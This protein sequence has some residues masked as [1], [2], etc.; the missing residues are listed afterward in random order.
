M[1]DHFGWEYKGKHKDLVA[2]YQQLLLYREALENPPLLVVCDLD[3]FE[4][5]TNFTGTAKQVHAFDLDGL[6]EAANLA[7]LRRPLHGAGLARPASPEKVTEDAAER[8][9]ELADGMRHADV[10]PRAAHFLMKL[11]FCMFGEDI[12][13]LPPGLRLAAET[14]KANP[15]MLPRL[16]R[17]CSTPW[18]TGG[19]F[20]A[21]AIDWFNG[22]LFADADVIPLT[23][24]E[25]NTWPPL[26]ITTGRASSRR[27]SARSSSGPWTRQAGADRRPLHQPGRYRGPAGAGAD[28]PLAPGM[29]RNQTR[30][31]EKLWPK[32]ARPAGPA[33]GK[34]AGKESP[35]RKAYDKALQDFAERLHHVT[36][37]D[38]AC[39]SGNFLYVA[40]NLLLDLEKEVM[41]YAAAHGLSLIPHVRPRSSRAGDQPLRAATAQV[42]IWIGYLQWMH[43]NGFKCPPS[44]PG[45][46][47]DHPLHGR[48]RRPLRPGASEG[49]ELAG[50]RRIVGNP[51]FLGGKLLRTNLGDPYVDSMFRLW[52]GRVP[53]RPTCAATGLRRPGRRSRSGKSAS[54][55]APGQ[56][57]NPR[58]GQPQGAR[59]DQGIR[60]HLLRR[61]RPRLGSGRR[62]GP[63]F[64]GRFR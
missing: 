48:H 9:A 35:Q 28:G 53:A 52:D 7:V 58:R 11:M 51:P 59:A 55:R 12:G 31:E 26:T 22:G 17:R 29:G 6:A 25:I 40:I 3:R 54:G 64:H 18:P 60:Q 37:L 34:A 61:E 20:G 1:R 5:H 46:D 50:G 24:A 42:V 57:G 13:L 36:V 14:A 15:A 41:A 43:H 47:R 45:A 16:L 44:H 21:D 63:C 39:G 2:A 49:A 30:C 8:F 23:P 62:G 33:G 10:P 27:S 32:V 4:I 56:P 19:D 38:P